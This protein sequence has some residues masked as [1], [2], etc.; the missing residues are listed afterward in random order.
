MIVSRF[1]KTKFNFLWPLLGLLIG[2]LA[3]SCQRVTDMS[4][5]WTN[6]WSNS[7]GGSN[8]SA[9]PQSDKSAQEDES[10]KKFS[11]FFSDEEIEKIF[12][13]GFDNQ[14]P[15]YMISHIRLAGPKVK[16]SLL[17]KVPDSFGKTRAEMTIH[18]QKE[19]LPHAENP[20]GSGV[21]KPQELIME[22]ACGPMQCG[23]SK[24]AMVTFK[25]TSDR[26]VL[27]RVLKILGVYVKKI[28]AKEISISRKSAGTFS[29]LTVTT[30]DE[31]KKNL[32]L[33]AGMIGI[34]ILG[35]FLVSCGFFLSRFELVRGVA[36]W[37]LSLGRRDETTGPPGAPKPEIPMLESVL[38]S[39]IS[40]PGDEPDTYVIAPPV[41]VSQT[42]MVRLM[43]A[44]ETI[45][46]PNS[47]VLP[48]PSH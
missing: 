35:A 47:A 14:N 10:S 13:H 27:L 16:E 38:I 5:G 21:T 48:S 37:F 28:A 22:V 29:L 33:V 36:R 44:V 3:V 24:N 7:R 1:L 20:K 25:T 26:Q 39:I 12:S 6:S 19:S 40:N 43:E 15:G 46:E 11:A 30:A 45:M 4:K 18:Y 42:S 34:V 2:S 9:V 31:G 41:T 32:Y 8:V 23:L 17:I